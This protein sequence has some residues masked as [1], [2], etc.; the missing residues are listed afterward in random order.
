MSPHARRAICSTSSLAF[1]M[2]FSA[3]SSRHAARDVHL[4]AARANKFRAGPPSRA[5]D[6]YADD[7][8]LTMNGLYDAR[9]APRVAQ[10]VAQSADANIDA[11]VERRAVAAAGEF[12]QLHA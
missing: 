4:G 11:S 12:D 3:T 8:A 1:C 2:Y 10:H 9:A 5:L 7:I 6:R